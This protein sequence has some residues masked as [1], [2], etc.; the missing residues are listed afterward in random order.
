M[1]FRVLKS[2]V[3]AKKK[4][5]LLH[6]HIL[7][8]LLL[9][10]N[11]LQLPPKKYYYILLSFATGKPCNTGPALNLARHKTLLLLSGGRVPEQAAQGVRGQP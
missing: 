9:F 7:L 5:S 2:F 10:Q 8:F 4:K 3:N 11:A 1:L 6:F